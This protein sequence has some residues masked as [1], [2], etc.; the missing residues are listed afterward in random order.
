M[1]R[2]SMLR[3]LMSGVA[4][5]VGALA[6]YL[7]FQRETPR[8]NVFASKSDF[9]IAQRVARNLGASNRTRQVAS[10]TTPTATNR[11]VDYQATFAA[12]RDYWALAQGLL[13]AAKAG[14]ADAQFYLYRTL[15][16]CDTNNRFYFIRPGKVRTLDE[17]RSWAA[18]RNLPRDEA[19]SVYER[20]NRF[21]NR[22]ASGFGASAEWL[23]QATNLGQPD[24]QSTT[25]EKAL[26]Q[27]ELNKV[28]RAGGVL[29]VTKPISPNASPR[30]LLSYALQSGDPYAMWVIGEVQGM[31]N[32]SGTDKAEGL[33]W[34]LAACHRGYDCSTTADWVVA[35][36]RT[37]ITCTVGN[38]GEDV[39]QA[40]AGDKW[41]AVQ[42]RAEVINDELN[43]GNWKAL[44]FG[45]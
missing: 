14:D 1:I 5:C 25:A 9:E 7:F 20:C 43:A 23:A 13:R 44:G 10:R 4:F 16:Y 12:S 42:Q 33:A 17:A 22:D 2:R 45:L 15:D 8:P 11:A 6:L 31:L 27:E 37:N 38:N 34:W 21:L 28:S 32:R 41:S 18:E 39:I 40:L 3:V 24:A 29:P 36:C 26:V 30:Q 35:M 19:L